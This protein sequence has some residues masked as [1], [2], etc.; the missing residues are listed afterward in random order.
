MG[1]PGFGPRFAW[2]QD[3][4]SSH[5]T[6]RNAFHHS[7][8]HLSS[9]CSWPKA[10]YLSLKFYNFSKTDMPWNV[11]L[12][13]SSKCN[14]RGKMYYIGFSTVASHS[15]LYAK[16]TLWLSKFRTYSVPRFPSQ[17]GEG[18]C[19]IWETVLKR[20]VVFFSS[21]FFWTYKKFIIKNFKQYIRA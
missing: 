17:R 11:I 10:R 14:K 7:N 13:V 16:Y 5:H 9:T 12:W 3:L 20:C 4:V 18:I 15:L 21:S 2:T 8:T 6:A 19:W 1:D